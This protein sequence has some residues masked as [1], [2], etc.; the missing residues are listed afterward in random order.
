MRACRR[1]NLM[2]LQQCREDMYSG[3]DQS[4][5]SMPY[6]ETVTTYNMAVVLV[7]RAAC[8]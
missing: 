5:L 8:K 4:V 2:A 7:L 3:K 1:D 6:N